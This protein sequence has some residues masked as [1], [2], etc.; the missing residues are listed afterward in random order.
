MISEFAFWGVFVTLFGLC[1]G[2]FLN[3]VILRGLS[4]ESIVFP[5]SK[6]PKCQK[7]LHWYTNIPIVSYIFLKGKCQFCKQP[8]SIQYPLVEA[9]NGILYLLLYL[10]YG[11][12]LQLLF[13]CAMASLFISI[14]TTDLKEHVVFNL[15]CYILGALG[16]LF[17]I[18]HLGEISIIESILGILAGYLV[19]AV[20]ALFGK[21]LAGRQALGGGDFLI[22]M[23]LGAFFGWKL[24]VV[25]FFAGVIFGSIL[26]YLPPIFWHFFKQKD[27][28]TAAAIAF[29]V[30]LAVVSHFLKGQ[31]VP[32]LLICA[33]LI[34]CLFVILNA[35]KTRKKEQNFL[36]IPLGPVFIIGALIVIF[37]KDVL[38]F[39]I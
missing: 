25:S 6:C 35:M 5:P 14:V 7:P 2:S 29:I 17:N 26:F 20:I 24:F 39:L 3:V 34:W 23:A 8:I 32:T 30:P 27:Y 4:G 11:L 36:Q 9:A 19:C 33:V 28:K 16:L 18:L 12:S 31:T 21:I 22:A 1:I 37:F 13:T 15:H 10:K 38:N